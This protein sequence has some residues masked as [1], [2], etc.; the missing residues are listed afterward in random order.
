MS[1]SFKISHTA[2]WYRNDF[3]GKDK[4]VAAR[5]SIPQRA[6][7]KLTPIKVHKQRREDYRLNGN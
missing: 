6:L 5:E 4:Q 3:N 2:K 1:S 7:I